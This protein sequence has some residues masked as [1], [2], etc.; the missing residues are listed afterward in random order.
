V[1]TFSALVVA[2][3]LVISL[4]AC[5]STPAD[6]LAACTPSVSEGSISKLVEATGASEPTVNFPTPLIATS[7]QR[8]FETVGEGRILKPG[9]IAEIQYSQLSGS[10]A[11]PVATSWD[12]GSLLYPVGSK[13][14]IADLLACTPIGSRIVATVPVSSYA[15][16]GAEI[17]EGATAVF[18]ID[19]LDGFA[20]K[21]DGTVHLQQNGF[22]AVVTAPN[23]QPGFQIPKTDAPTE[24]LTEQLQT[25]HGDTVEEGDDVVVQMA[26]IQ[27]TT[28][29]I[30]TSTWETSPLRTSASAS[31]TVDTDNGIFL[32]GTVKQ[33]LVGK[34]V[35]SQLLFVVPA[36]YG[37]EG[38]GGIA[39]DETLVY[40]V[41]ILAI[42]K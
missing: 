18:V 28:N 12:T 5:S 22:P 20:G 21:A 33:K 23:G 35:G 16:E 26:G 10:D 37:F 6:Q 39:A 40:V 4:A 17:P 15:A 31:D 8:S 13:D 41:D 42:Q 7:T 30:L 9:D 25:G 14:F 29:T 1:R 36:K 38:G 32:P 34:T 19:V 24:F 2:T 11:S 27:W 3:G